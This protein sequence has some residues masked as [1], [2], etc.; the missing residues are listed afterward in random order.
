MSGSGPASERS[1]IDA[2]AGVSAGARVT[3]GRS[4]RPPG[5]RDGQTAQAVQHVARLV[6]ERGEVDA[7][8]R[9]GGRRGAPAAPRGRCD[10]R[11]G[12]ARRRG[13]S[14]RRGRTPGG[15]SGPG[16]HGS[17]WPGSSK[18][19]GV[20]VAGGIDEHEVVAGGDRHA[21]DLGVDHGRAVQALHRRLEAQR[22]FD[23]AGMRAGSSRRRR[24]SSGCSSSRRT[25]E[26]ISFVV[27]SLP[28]TRNWLS[29]A[30]ISSSRQ[31]L[32]VDGRR[33]EIGDEILPRLGPPLGDASAEVLEE[34][35]LRQQHDRAARRARWRGCR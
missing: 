15:S 19:A 31:R 18:R 1:K 9:D 35:A 29:M 3:R 17:T 4:R 13:R 7:V 30:R 5:E 16:R 27:V 23:E 25:D 32:V 20:T 24:C 2:T 21:A 22:L 14:A 10:P 34:L 26:A 12:P 28:A 33:H 6:V 8:G 11:R